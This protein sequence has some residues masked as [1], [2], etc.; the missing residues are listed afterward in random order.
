MPAQ[1]GTTPSVERHDCGAVT[2]L[3]LKAPRLVDD[4]SVRAAFDPINALV[5]E[6]GRTRLVLN[7]AAVEYLPSMALAV[8]AAL[9]RQ[10]RAGGGRLALCQVPATVGDRLVST[11]LGSL[12][13]V[14]ATEEE[15]VQSYE[16]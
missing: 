10:A 6:A 1:P 12:F 9:G 3:R 8:L 15:A 16:G 7:L 2:V 5:G 13:D 14:Y 11:H 4:D